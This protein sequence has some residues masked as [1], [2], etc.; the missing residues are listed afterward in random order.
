M[1]ANMIDGEMDERLALALDSITARTMDGEIIT[2]EVVQREFPDVA[3]LLRDLLPTI[4]TMQQWGQGLNI[5]NSGDAS[6]ELPGSKPLGDFRIIREIGRGGMG[7]VY[8]AEQMALRRRV[9]VKVLP[10]AGLLDPRQLE[11]F[12]N[13]ARAAA[14]LKHPNIA[15][16]HAVGCERGVHYYAMD[17][18][19]GCSIAEVIRSLA[20]PSRREAKTRTTASDDALAEE[21]T[22]IAELRTKFSTN[23]SGFYISV[24]RIGVESAH[25]LEFAHQH[26]IIHR[27]VKPSN[28]IL[29]RSGKVHVADFGLAL[30]E[31]STNVTLTGDVIGTLRYMSPEQLEE[32]SAVDAR[33]DIYSLGAT[34][35][36]MICG[37]SVVE[38]DNRADLLRAVIDGEPQKLDRLDAEVPRDLATIVMKC[39]AKSPQDR[40][41]S[42]EALVEDLQRFIENRPVLARRSPP[43]RNAWKWAVRHKMLAATTASALLTL[44]TLAIAGPVAA[45]L[46][47]N[48]LQAEQQL[49]HRL[50]MQNYDM[51]VRDASRVIKDGNFGRAEEM[52]QRCEREFR[53]FEW[54][55]L[56][57][58]VKQHQ[59]DT[60]AKHPI[61]AMRVAVSPDRTIV[62]C[63]NWYGF[64][65]LYDRD[66]HKSLARFRI[67]PK[68]TPF[69]LEFSPNGAYL[70][71]GVGK[72]A[73]LWDVDESKVASTRVFSRDLS[74]A[75]FSP[76]GDLLAIGL[77]KHVLSF[78]GREAEPSSIRVLDVSKLRASGD[79]DAANGETVRVLNT[80]GA[81][82][83]LGF[84]PDGKSLLAASRA[85]A[86]IRRWE[87][88]SYRESE[89][90]VTDDDSVD[91]FAIH[92]DGMHIAVVSS[93]RT[94]SVNRVS[95]FSL[96]AQMASRTIYASRSR[97]KCL[98]FSPTGKQ[99]ALGQ[100]DGHIASWTWDS[101]KWRDRSEPLT[102][103][104]A[105]PHQ[106]TIYDLALS[107]TGHSVIS[108]GADGYFKEV[109][110]ADTSKT[111]DVGAPFAG[112]IEFLGDDRAITW[113]YGDGANRLRLW[114]LSDRT[115]V[116]QLDMGE[117]CVTDAVLLPSKQGIA[118]VGY[119]HPKATKAVIN[120]WGLATGTTR[121]LYSAK[122]SRSRDL[123]V[124]TSGKELIAG[125]GANLVVLDLESRQLREHKF[126]GN[127]F[128]VAQDQN[129]GII[130]IG[131][132][133]NEPSNEATLWSPRSK[134][135]EGTL[136]CGPHDAWCLNFS[137]DGKLAAGTGAGSV[138]I[139]DS[140]EPRSPYR[141]LAGH[142][143][144]AYYV[145]FSPSGKRIAS[146][147]LDSTVRL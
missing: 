55:L 99:L 70:F 20:F 47:Q 58:Q 77:M 67:I 38:G 108:A 82:T 97:I 68:G 9:A 87:V 8:E 51:L 7:V 31:N 129:S 44:L 85:T 15:S 11:R 69:A 5:G 111:L 6:A 105:R 35:Y 92:N 34:L 89:P 147:G 64:V 93:Q 117:I 21:T 37:Q 142:A 41:Q 146:A 139:W 90:I 60:I 110:L 25:A 102:Q 104:L 45:H 27:D 59:S 83:S 130:A 103:V 26:G 141:E 125:I 134:S 131:A 120:S 3:H 78:E 123:L 145:R 86:T 112:G 119:D 62:A 17:L 143:A 95:V 109:F 101:K 49:S 98:Q 23:R 88:P 65:H 127:A 22:P 18:I 33:T 140:L 138:L 50:R 56:W 2:E 126:E 136:R 54:P 61:D 118:Y 19:D 72:T 71:A 84:T 48:A 43:W 63:G 115:V 53:E 39:V 57:E 36:E 14:M 121:E 96:D 73:V 116:K 28:L 76:D 42:A 16:V 52:L 30:I 133:K 132:S 91:A 113:S 122:E 32:A 144:N 106:S 75:A 24:A 46:L 128:P 74:A 94:G 107:S 29:D 137:P 12:K 10:F 79:S 13:E 1:K 81:I 40:Y 124:S 66:S 4:T 114:R 100:A 135:V 80:T